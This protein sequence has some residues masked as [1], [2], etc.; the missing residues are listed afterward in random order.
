[1]TRLCQSFLR[2]DEVLFVAAYGPT[3]P[4]LGLAVRDREAW[5]A[6]QQGRT[7]GSRFIVG[8]REID[9]VAKSDEFSA[10]AEADPLAAPAPASASPPQPNKRVGHVVVGVSTVPM[11]NAQR[12]QVRFTIIVAVCAAGA[13]ATIL[14]FGL[15][16]WLQRL[17]KLADASQLISN[18]DF[19]GSLADYHHDEIGRLACSFEEMRVALQHRDQN[20]QRFTDTLQDQV[21]KRTLDL[22]TALA[23]AEEASR[24]KSLFLANM[25]HELRTP[26]NGVIG[27]VDLMLAAEPNVQ[28]R[29]YCDIAKSSARSLLELINDILDFS[30]I[31]AGKLEMETADFDLH[32][33]IESVAGMFGE[34][35]EQKKIELICGLSP[36]VPRMANG[37]PVRL[38]QVLTNLISNALKFTER[39]EVVVRVALEDEDN[40]SVVI[41]FSVKDSGIG[42]PQDR[43]ARLFQ[44][45]SQVD[46]STTRKFGGT[47]LG[48][49]ISQRIVQMMNGKI[50]V[51]SQEGLGA[52]FWFTVRFEKSSRQLPIRNLSQVDPAR[53]ARACR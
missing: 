51:E 50:G 27:M 12:Q 44:S 33:A 16:S 49:A 53:F 2:D 1:M 20:L 22:R 32:E 21:Q 25:S 39:G 17:R 41:K 52:T 13:S 31:E 15:G 38:R 4:P 6:Y 40:S 47:G 48:L 24:T 9:Q 34:R 42:I 35:A 30:K 18:G 46:A 10:D 8:V 43:M 14:F 28:Q 5:E 23:A 3:S 19:T 36:Q 11:M 45:F 7:D 26:L 29:R 37:D